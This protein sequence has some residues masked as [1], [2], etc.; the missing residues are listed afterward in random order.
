MSTHAESISESPPPQAAVGADWTGMTGFLAMI[1]RAVEA[2]NWYGKR[3]HFVCGGGFHGQE[4]LMRLL[5]YCAVVGAVTMEE[6]AL[7]LG[8]DSLLRRLGS[9]SVPDAETL[10]RFGELQ[11]EALRRC[12]AEFWQIASLLHFGADN[13]PPAPTDDCVARQFDRWLRPVRRPETF[14]NAHDPAGHLL[15]EFGH[16]LP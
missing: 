13:H 6:I 8:T 14:P 11:A 7:R 12:L 9:E 15:F 3:S 16:K 2:V 1:V 10:L 4:T 5:M